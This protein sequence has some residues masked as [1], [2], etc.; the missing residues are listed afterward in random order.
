LAAARQGS[1]EVVYH[2]PLKVADYFDRKTLAAMAEAEVRSGLPP[3]LR[4]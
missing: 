4:G 3:E 2:T 1:V